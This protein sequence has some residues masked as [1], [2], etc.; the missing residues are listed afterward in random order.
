MKTNKIYKIAESY[1]KEYKYI[2]YH[3]KDDEDFDE[4]I[5]D[6]NRRYLDEFQDDVLDLI[7]I[8]K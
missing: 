7:F 2:Q 8:L 4:Q 5:T 6:L 1:I 3:I